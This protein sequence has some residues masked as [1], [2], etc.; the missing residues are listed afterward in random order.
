[1]TE[2]WE[3]LDMY[4]NTANEMDN[5]DSALLQKKSNLHFI[6]EEE[7]ENLSKNQ[8]YKKDINIDINNKTTE[9]NIE[10]NKKKFKEI[11]KDIVLQKK[12]IIKSE[13]DV[14]LHDKET[15]AINIQEVNSEIKK[16]TDDTET[17]E[18]SE[19]YIKKSENN[20]IF[21]LNNKK[22]N[23]VNYFWKSC[24]YT[25]NVL[26]DVKNNTSNN[27]KYYYLKTYNFANKYCYD[28]SSIC[29]FSIFVGL[30]MYIIHYNYQQLCNRISNIENSIYYKPNKI[31]F[32]HRN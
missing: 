12:K 3:N 18:G 4:E 20:I 13:N 30:Y 1:M 14:L 23:F 10:N 16:E 6:D 5:F 11:L 25:K 8:Y 7:I 29:I 22:D 21:K 2:S 9:N 32:I 26:V 28:V 17:S 24:N 15:H 19:K 27:I 31:Y